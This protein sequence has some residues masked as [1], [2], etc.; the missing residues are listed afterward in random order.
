MASDVAAWYITTI[1]Q[2][3]SS[4]WEPF[5]HPKKKF[6]YD[7]EDIKSV[8][9]SPLRVV[10]KKLK[11]SLSVISD[12]GGGGGVPNLQAMQRLVNAD[13]EISATIFNTKTILME[14]MIRGPAWL[15]L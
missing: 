6:L 12:S 4:N 5:Q 14:F 1:C 9:L 10:F 2:P 8:L 11:V 7:C 3:L 15:T 13:L